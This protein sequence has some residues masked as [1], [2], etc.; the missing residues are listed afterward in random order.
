MPGGNS[1]EV[2][3]ISPDEESFEEKKMAEGSLKDSGICHMSNSTFNTKNN[4]SESEINSVKDNIACLDHFSW[5]R[6][7]W[8]NLLTEKAFVIG[9][10]RID[11][12]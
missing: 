1:K 12:L 3:L 8:I 9:C 7:T 2:I 11:G 6:M 5:R 4:I 10:N